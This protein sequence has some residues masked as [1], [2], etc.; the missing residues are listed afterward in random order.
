MDVPTAPPYLVYLVMDF[1]FPDRPKLRRRP[2]CKGNP[3]RTRVVQLL[4]PAWMGAA[5]AQRLFFDT[6][7]MPGVAEEIRTSGDYPSGLYRVETR[8]SSGLIIKVE[9]V[10]AP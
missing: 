6:E 3:A 4:G 7:H 9:L 1:R 8:D 5:R 10:H 2:R